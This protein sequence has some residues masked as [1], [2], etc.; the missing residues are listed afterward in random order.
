ML[1]RFAGASLPALGARTMPHR[2]LCPPL[3]TVRAPRDRLATTVREPKDKGTVETGCASTR[4]ACAPKPTTV[5][6]RLRFLFVFVRQPSMPQQC[7]LARTA[8]CS[9]S[10]IASGFSSA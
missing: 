10:N 4:L 8:R 3:T 9:W 2:P 7:R 1:S 5:G 6:M